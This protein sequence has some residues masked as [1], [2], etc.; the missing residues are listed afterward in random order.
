MPRDYKVYLEDIVEAINK[1]Q[2][3]TG[4]LSKQ[5]FFNDFKTLDAVVRNLE[6]IG[7]AMKKVP[8][9]VRSRHLGVEWKSNIITR[10]H[11]ALLRGCYCD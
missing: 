2:S 3:Y 5:A 9:D 1:I 11:T 7:E 10:R 6:I 4:N 8:E